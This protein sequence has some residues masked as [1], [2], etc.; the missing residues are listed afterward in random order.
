MLAGPMPRRGVVTARTKAGVVVLVEQQP[1]V[2][3]DVADLDAVEVGLPAGEGVGDLVLA[4][5]LLE[6]PPLMVTAIEDGIVAPAAAVLETVGIEP[7][8]HPFGLVLGIAAGEH[9]DRVALAVLGP[10]AL[11]ESLSLCAM[12]VLAALRIP[13]VER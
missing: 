1:Q 3:H 10:Q 5:G 7:R 13:A 12:S 9:G 6:E 11:V 2:G 4:Q 8:R